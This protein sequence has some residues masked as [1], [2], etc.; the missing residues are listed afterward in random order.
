MSRI[1]NPFEISNVCMI[2][3]TNHLFGNSSEMSKVAKFLTIY[4][5]EKFKI[6]GFSSVSIDFMTF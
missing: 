6:D 1:G 4:Y 5:N 3:L 2:F